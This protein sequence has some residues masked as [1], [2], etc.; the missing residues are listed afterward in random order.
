MLAHAV[1]YADRDASWVPAQ[2]QFVE[3]LIA[4]RAPASAT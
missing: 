1:V 3:L 4:P 2:S